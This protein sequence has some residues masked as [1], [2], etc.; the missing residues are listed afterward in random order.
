MS[1]FQKKVD[2]VQVSDH[3]L[4]L[5]R[6]ATSTAIVDPLMY[7]I[8]SSQFITLFQNCLKSCKRAKTKSIAALQGGTMIKVRRRFYLL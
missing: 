2:L 6:V 7:H 8:T 5:Y 4:M 3:G 1:F